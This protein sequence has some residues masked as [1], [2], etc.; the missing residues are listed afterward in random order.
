LNRKRRRVAACLPKPSARFFFCLQEA[1][2]K[3]LTKRKCRKEDFAACGRRPTPHGV[4]AVPP[5]EKGGRKLLLRNAAK[6]FRRA[7][8]HL[9]EKAGENF[10]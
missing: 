5:F 7:A 3:K 9:L 1:Q 8:R 4:G 2:K 10:Y 6:I